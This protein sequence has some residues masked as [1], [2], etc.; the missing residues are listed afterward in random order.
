[1]T[2]AGPVEQE[3]STTAAAMIVSLV[4]MRTS[5]PR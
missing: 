3:A 1:V 4:E 2:D 5:L